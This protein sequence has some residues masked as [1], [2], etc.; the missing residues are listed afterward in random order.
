LKAN[1][2]SGIVDTPIFRLAE[3]R[4][5]VDSKTFSAQTLLKRM[6]KPGEIA[7]VMM[8]MLSDKAAYVTGCK[9]EAG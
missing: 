9:P 5:I 8:F 7:D 1:N 2:Q 3:S 4:G 6:G